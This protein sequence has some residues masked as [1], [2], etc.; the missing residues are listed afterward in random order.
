MTCC[1]CKHCSFMIPCSAVRS[2]CSPIYR[3]TYINRTYS[4]GIPEIFIPE[5]ITCQ[6]SQSICTCLNHTITDTITIII[7][8]HLI[9]CISAMICRMCYAIPIVFAMSLF[10][11][12]SPINITL[13]SPARRHIFIRLKPLH[14]RSRCFPFLF[15]CNVPPLKRNFIN[16][17]HLKVFFRCTSIYL[18]LSS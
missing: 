5:Y 18:C 9:R 8:N 10:I 17:A 2:R 7:E 1:R 12:I 6:I 3:I 16:A 11:T 15:H 14:H 13:N 4:S